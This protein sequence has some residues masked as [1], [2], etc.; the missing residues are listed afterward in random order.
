MTRARA[1]H[2]FESSVTCSLS[3]KDGEVL[4]VT[5]DDGTVSERPLSQKSLIQFLRMKLAKKLVAAAPIAAVSVGNGE[6]VK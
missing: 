6:P 1:I 3:G 2:A 5:F 4:V